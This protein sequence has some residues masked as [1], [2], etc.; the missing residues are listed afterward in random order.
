MD[1]YSTP[2]IVQCAS[3]LNI[4]NKCTAGRTLSID[5]Q[6]APL[7]WGGNR[8]PNQAIVVDAGDRMSRSVEKIMAAERV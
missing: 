8:V 1:D 4:S 3:G 2:T 6:D 7:P 5:D